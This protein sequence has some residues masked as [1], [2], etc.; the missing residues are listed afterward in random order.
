MGA[1]GGG[2]YSDVPRPR[3]VSAAPGPRERAPRARIGSDNRR[4]GDIVRG[5]DEHPAP[6]SMKR[7]IISSVVVIAAA[8]AL[9]GVAFTK[10]KAMRKE[11]ARSELGPLT[12]LVRAQEARRGDYT[13]VLKGF[14]RAEAL[15][16]AVVS[17]EVDGIVRTIDPRLEAGTAIEWAEPTDGAGTAA[18]PAPGAGELVLPVLVEL[19]ARDLDDMLAQA[20]AQ[21]TAAE[22]E[23]ARLASVKGSLRE[24]LAITEE[25][26]ATAERELARIEPLVPKTFTNSDLDR[27]RLEVTLRRGQ[28]IALDSQ[29]KENT[30]A[31]RAAVARKA[32][33]DRAVALAERQHGRAKVRA[34]FAG[35]IE[36]RH[37]NVGERVRVGD[38]LFTIVDL[39]KTEV[40]I[41]LSAGS[42]DDLAADAPVHL[43]LPDHD[44][45]L[46]SGT[47]ARIAPR[48]NARERTFFAY[49][50]VAGTPTSNP[51]PP[52]THLIA[53]VEGRTHHSVIA[54]PRRAFLGDRLF[55]ARP[56][57]GGETYVV[58]E[59]TPT[60]ERYLAGV[61]LVTEG[62]EA[63]DLF[64]VT[65]LESVSDG[66]HVR[67]AP[68]EK[69]G[70]K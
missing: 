6:V 29:V 31:A 54:V 57:A 25:E 21:A 69:A 11:S 20:R 10:L 62:L 14:G 50:L 34:P 45:D 53:S 15:Q 60:V 70:A 41:A 49:A 23:V 24:R 42:Y 18:A 8:F 33:A 68:E 36:E 63:G 51:A 5:V 38:P 27:Q 30:E 65:N 1:P 58:E 35:R 4:T 22:A 9:A 32:A 40:P 43:R 46:W 39:T 44:E 48:I 2:S 66:S 47:L 55:V 67:L 7:R 13:E 59:R 3:R 26:L 56:E 12:P 61:A 52:G 64:L 19:D 17:A 16:R 37:V 28:K